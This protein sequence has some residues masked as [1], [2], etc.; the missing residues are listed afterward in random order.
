MTKTNERRLIITA[1][2]SGTLLEWYDFMLFGIF[3]PIISHLFFPSNNHIASLLATFGT[4]ALG[5]LSRPIGAIIMGNRGDKKG[6]KS[7]FLI[8]L[9][10]MIIPS[11]LI[12]LL[13]TYQTIGI[14]SPILL[15]I[16]RIV[17]GISLGGESSGAITYLA[18][19]AKGKERSLLS[20]LPLLSG[21]AGILLSS[22]LGFGLTSYLSE[23]ALHSWGW[24]LPFLL[25][26]VLG[27][28]SF[29]LRTRMQET[30]IFQELKNKKTTARLPIKA[31]FQKQRKTLVTLTGALMLSVAFPYFLFFYLPSFVAENPAIDNNSTFFTN[32]WILLA[33]LFFIP[34]ASYFVTSRWRKQLMMWMCIAIM[35]L[36]FPVF[37]FFLNQNMIDY[38]LIVIL[39]G[40]FTTTYLSN[41]PALMAENLDHQFRY[42]GTSLAMNLAAAFFGGPVPFFM[43]YFS[44][45]PYFKY[46]AASYFFIIALVSLIS[47]FVLNHQN[48]FNDTF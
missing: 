27:A 48:K 16:F 4:F 15:I 39:L 47:L 17:Q 30:T 40:F 2:V 28:I 26:I 32:S 9:V 18:E 43:T 31:I 46:L 45:S 5:F 6:R 33:T 13:P 12:G 44:A 10:L 3:S 7:T 21:H 22:L 38:I 24:R 36:I 11:I 14:L 34:L 8:S 20:A 35:L 29:Y 19:Y 25:T 41:A 42:T 23:D 1:C 37:H